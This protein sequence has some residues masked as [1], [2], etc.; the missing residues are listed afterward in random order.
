[1]VLAIDVGNTNI[2][3]GVFEEDKLRFIARISS[4]DISQTADELAIKIKAIFE[5]R[6]TDFSKISGSILSSVVPAVTA[7][8]SD[9]ILLLT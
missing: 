5:I 7:T 9:A 2:V 1:M 3:L 6:E 8:L 4:S